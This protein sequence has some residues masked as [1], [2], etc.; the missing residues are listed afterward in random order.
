[1]SK[2]DRFYLSAATLQVLAREA[3]A[4]MIRAFD[5][6]PDLPLQSISL[7]FEIY[8]LESLTRCS[9]AVPCIEWTED[10]WRRPLSRRSWSSSRRV[11]VALNAVRRGARFSLQPSPPQQIPLIG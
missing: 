2:S 4:A 9:M 7:P 10:Q 5:G 3:I 11:M 8:A 1:M 6:G